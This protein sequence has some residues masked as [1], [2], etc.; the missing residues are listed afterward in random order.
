MGEIIRGIGLT[1]R[2]GEGEAAVTA[3]DHVD[4]SIDE[5]ELLVITGDSGSGK[6]TLI[7]LL[8]CIL[9]PTEGEVWIEGKRIDPFKDE[10]PRIR[11]E[12]IGFVFQLF[13]LIPYLTAL[14]N[15]LIAMEIN[16]KRGPDAEKR[17]KEILERVGLGDR[18]HHRPSQLSGGEKQ[19]VSF[20]R[21]MANNPQVIF[22]DEPTAN[23][24]SHQSANLM[25]LI[26]ELRR[27]RGTTIVVVTHQLALIKDSADRILRMK[28]GK[29]VEEHKM[30]EV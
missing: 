27:E 6:T 5:G 20:A 7:S 21:A 10:L 16:G 11:R 14:E 19:R 29:I 24:D 12:K 2:F 28:D 30:K 13:N 23:L 18:L 25:E 1:K 15:V 17:A 4:I 22:A 8:G 9:R 3:V 26:R